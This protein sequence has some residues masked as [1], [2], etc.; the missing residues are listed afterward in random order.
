MQIPRPV[1]GTARGWVFGTLAI[2]L[3]CAIAVWF[4]LASTLGKP[5]WTNL[6]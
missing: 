6:G 4:G 2:L 3:G 5:S 1:P